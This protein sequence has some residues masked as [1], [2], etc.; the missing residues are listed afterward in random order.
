[1]SSNRQPFEV[2]D[3]IRRTSVAAN[4]HYA[5]KVATVAAVNDHTIEVSWDP[6]SPIRQPQTFYGSLNGAALDVL[7]ERVPTKTA[8]D[9]DLELV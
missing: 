9:D 6:P 1:M 8:W 5:G 3:R 2:G 7:F 4:P